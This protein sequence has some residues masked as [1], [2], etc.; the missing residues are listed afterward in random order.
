MSIFR[1]NDGVII[2][3]AA[4]TTRE[5]KVLI[6][7]PYEWQKE[8]D[9]VKVTLNHNQTKHITIKSMTDC[10]VNSRHS[11]D[12]EYDEIVLNKFASVELKNLGDVWYIL[13]SDGL[14]NS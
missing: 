10:I 4:Y 11:F 1:N 7:R 14:K 3:E 8:G 6:V 2:R 5:E 9:Q 12:G 13:S